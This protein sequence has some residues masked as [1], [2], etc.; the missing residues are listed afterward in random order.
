MQPVHDAIAQLSRQD[1]G[2]AE[3]AWR[4]GERRGLITHIRARMGVSARRGTT[5][6]PGDPERAE[7]LLAAL[8][9]YRQRSKLEWPQI[10]KRLGS[11][12]RASVAGSTAPGDRRTRAWTEL[13][14]F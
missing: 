5:T 13:N 4:L 7:R 12:S 14:G 9:D 11:T 10:A 8:K 6:K 1:L 3:I 2:P